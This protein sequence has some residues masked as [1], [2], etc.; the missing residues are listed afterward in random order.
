MTRLLIIFSFVALL[1]IPGKGQE[2]TPRITKVINKTISKLWKNQD[3]QQNLCCVQHDLE[4]EIFFK[5]NLLYK[6]TAAGQD[7]GWLVLRRAYGCK[8]GGCGSGNYSTASQVC[9]A[10][11]NAYE[12]FDYALF[13]N[14]QLEILKVVVVDY[15]GDYGYEITSPGWLNQFIGYNGGDLT[16]GS[17]VDAISGATI[18]ANSIT[19]DIVKVHGMMEKVVIDTNMISLK[20]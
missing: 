15:P 1:V 19:W 11:G 6:L 13:L 14:E 16:Y 8:V 18:S 7:K 5:G 10:D 20:N 17:D 9:A 3:I 12:V 2:F 4:S